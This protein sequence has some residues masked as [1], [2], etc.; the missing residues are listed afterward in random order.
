MPAKKTKTSTPKTD[1]KAAQRAHAIAT[2]KR[3]DGCMTLA[4]IAVDMD[5]T[6]DKAR[7]HI[8]RLIQSG[9]AE[10]VPGKAIN[11]AGVVIS[12]TYYRLLRTE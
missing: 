6:E 11:T 10:R 7:E 8:N 4:E 12:A 5:L 1:W 9:W 3:P 2:V